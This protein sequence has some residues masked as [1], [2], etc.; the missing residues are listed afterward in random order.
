MMHDD[1]GDSVPTLFLIVIVI[2]I[3]IALTAGNCGAAH[4]RVRESHL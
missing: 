4:A 3:A 2:V 1:D